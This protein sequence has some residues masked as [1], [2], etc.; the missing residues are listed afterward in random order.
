MPL[1]TTSKPQVR[2]FPDP[3]FC[4]G[5]DEPMMVIHFALLSQGSTGGVSPRAALPCPDLVQ[6]GSHETLQARHDYRLG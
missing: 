5:D 1:P 2:T 3:E 4:N 6:G